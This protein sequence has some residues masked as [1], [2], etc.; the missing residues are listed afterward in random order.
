MMTRPP[1]YSFDT[2]AMG[3]A[4]SYIND[5]W[6]RLKRFHPH[7]DG[8]LVGLPRPY[9][10]P[11][12]NN[13]Q[14]FDFEELYYWDSYFI[15][16]A[17]LGTPQHKLAQDMTDNL[18]Y[19]MHR[20]G[21]I[22]N[23]GRSY[24]TSRSQPPILTTLILQLYQENGNREWLSEAITTAK[25]EYRR[26]WLGISQ[27]NW[28]QVFEGLSRYYDANMLNELAE[29]E[30]GWDMTSRFDRRCLDYI[31]VDLNAL[32]YKYETDF[33]HVAMINFDTDEAQ[34]WHKRAN[35]RT[36]T[37]QKYLWDD[38]RGF[39]FD[40]NYRTG[41]RSQVWSLAG[42]YPMWAGMVSRH[43][44]AHMVANLD[45]FELAG[46]LVTTA[47]LPVIH[48]ELPEQWAYPN[49]WAP[50]QMIVVEALERYGYHREAKR[51]ARKWLR[52]NLEFFNAHG[53]FYE[54][55]NVA[56]PAAEPSDGIY[57]AQRG[58]GWTN[59]VFVRF[60]ALYLE[61]SEL[62]VSTPLVDLSPHRPRL[63]DH[64]L[65]PSLFIK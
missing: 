59:A 35:N 51:I 10:I 2:E 46:G 28:R 62:P 36:K 44:A 27:P 53:E 7:D 17:F 16:Q 43:Q 58:F 6:S 29:A 1:N 11:S 48:S 31:P 45:K 65:L 18:L 14:G 55:Y 57:P 13:G 49:G 33:A 50:L 63:R 52:T 61:P 34:E 26:V 20:F 42:F 8:T 40:Y 19:L 38:K 47:K 56:H 9:V 60:A 12:G 3:R 30:S 21:I 39:F 5:Y 15:A 41:R 64:L 4:T 22:P 25:E 54:K 32:L 24:L 37:M 23:G